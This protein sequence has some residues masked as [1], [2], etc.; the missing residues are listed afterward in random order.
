ME[1]FKRTPNIDFMGK[2][3]VT[4]AV[5]V[6]LMVGSFVLLGVRG[7]NFGID[8]TGGDRKSVV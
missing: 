4:Y 6:L 1:F 3:R 5:S 2:R 8:F 7:L